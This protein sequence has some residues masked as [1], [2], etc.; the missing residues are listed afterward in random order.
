MDGRTLDET[1][2]SR[3][4][5][6][7]PKKGTLSQTE[8]L[9]DVFTTKQETNQLQNSKFKKET[10][11][12]VVNGFT[13]GRLSLFKRNVGTYKRVGGWGIPNSTNM[14]HNPPI[15]QYVLCLLPS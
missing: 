4:Y 10:A 13:Q 5:A 11:L 3:N 8:K 14:R 7:A 15:H 12:S 1:V 2:T 9:M 6:E